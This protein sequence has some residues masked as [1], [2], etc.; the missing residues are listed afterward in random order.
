MKWGGDQAE[1]AAQ[2]GSSQVATLALWPAG[3]SAGYGGEGCGGCRLLLR[4]CMRSKEAAEGGGVEGE[5][6]QAAAIGGTIVK[7]GHEQALR[8]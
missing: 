3:R 2:P 1:A 6:A 4:C 8:P 5:K 7:V